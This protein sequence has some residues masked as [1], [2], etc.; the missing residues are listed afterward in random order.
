MTDYVCRGELC[1]IKDRLD[2]SSYGLSE[3]IFQRENQLDN[4]SPEL[5]GGEKEK[6]LMASIDT[7]YNASELIEGAITLI[8]GVIQ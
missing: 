6:K 7:L 8:D 2:S 4:L 3:V 5:R 1:A